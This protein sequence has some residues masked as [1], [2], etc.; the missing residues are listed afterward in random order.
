PTSLRL[1]FPVAEGAFWADSTTL[2]Q[3]VGGMTITSSTKLD[4]TW[5]TGWGTLLTPA[6]SEPALRLYTKTITRIPGLPTDD[7]GEQLDF[8]TRDGRIGASIVLDDGRAFH[9]V[10][11]FAPKEPTSLLRLEETVGF[12]KVAPNPVADGTTIYFRTVRPGRVSLRLWDVWGRPVAEIAEQEY[13]AGA[14]QFS[15][16]RDEDIPA[17][18]YLL[19]LAQGESKR[20]RKLILR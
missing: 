19:E 1:A 12:D 2:N 5:V 17:G 6:G 9:T 10:T 3:R 14:H 11:D 8:V 13:P 16:R 15:W 4:S 20:L 7:V 18:T